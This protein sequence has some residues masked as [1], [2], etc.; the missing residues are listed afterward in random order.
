MPRGDPRFFMGLMSGTSADGVDAVVCSIFGRG[1]RIS[2]QV[3]RHFH[4]PF[5]APLRRRILAAGGGQ[6]MDSAEFCRLNWRLGTFFAGAA[7]AAL[8][9]SGFSPQRITAI[10][11]HGQT[12]SHLPPAAHSTGKVAGTWQIGEPTVIAESLGVPVVARFREADMAAGGQGAPLVPWTDFVLLGH[13][14]KSR[15]V[16]NIGGIANLTWL[17]AG[18]SAE[19]VRA[20]D[21]GPGNMVMDGLI[22]RLTRGRILFDR[23]GRIAARGRIIEPLLKSWLANPF[24]RI[25]P[26]RSCGREQFGDAFVDEALRRTGRRTRPADLLATATMLTARSIA[27]GYQWLKPRGRAKAVLIDEVILCGGGARN[28]TLRRMLDDLLPGVGQRTIDEFGIGDQQKEALSFAMLAAA[29]IDGIPANLPAVTGA[30]RRVLL[31]QIF[32]AN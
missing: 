13:P 5:P 24:F 8:R 32:T 19:D 4:Q 17:P 25:C 16:Q 18:G 28:M 7:A 15:V 9:K 1:E 26:P 12:I 2:A 27:A 6:A 30:R 20:F 11:S 10:G 23:G 21:T 29:R 14:R 31:G 3:V 22:R